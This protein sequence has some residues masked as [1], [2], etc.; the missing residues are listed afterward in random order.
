MTTLGRVDIFA[1]IADERR[2]TAD[3]CESLTD[4]Q[5]ATP[6]LC[7]GWTVHDVAA[8]LLMP[9]VTSTWSFAVAMLRHR[10]NFDR[11][12]ADLTAAVAKRGNDEIIAGLRERADSHF[13]PPGMGPQAP[14]A[15][16]L[17]HGEDMRR[18]LGLERTFD[19]QRLTTALDFLTSGGRLGYVPESRLTGLRFVATDLAWTFGEGVD[20]RGPAESLML[21]IAG[22]PVALADLAGDGVSELGARIGAGAA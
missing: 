13:T 16:L 14:L 17:I 21:V 4:E 10:M 15:D 7:E 9:L 18:P 2:I 8:H 12:N 3:F 20:V 5:W 11:A 6:S 1:D 19:A 22:R